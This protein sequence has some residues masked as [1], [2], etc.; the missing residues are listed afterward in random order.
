MRSRRADTKRNMLIQ[1]RAGH[2]TRNGGQKSYQPLGPRYG[3]LAKAAP[4]SGLA[5]CVSSCAIPTLIYR[6]T[7][8]LRAVQPLLGHTKLESTVKYRD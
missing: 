7:K 1:H 2:T 4:W 6:R 8:N 3:I 5:A